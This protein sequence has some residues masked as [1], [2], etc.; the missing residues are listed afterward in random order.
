MED[1]KARP[2]P[3]P[4]PA[5]QAPAPAA[6]PRENQ[7]PRADPRKKA[8][9][10]TSI[11]REPETASVEGKKP[12]GIQGKRAA[13][14]RN[15]V[16]QGSKPIAEDVRTESSTIAP[17]KA[18][19]REA[20]SLPNLTATVPPPPVKDE[21]SWPTP[22]KAE[23]TD[24]EKRKE[25][26]DKEA[27]NSA[28]AG[29]T[30]AKPRERTKWTPMAVT[31]S[32]VWQ[33]EEMNRPRGGA[34][35]RARGGGRGGPN[36]GKGERNAPRKEGAQGE[37][38]NSKDAGAR[39][40]TNTVDREVMPPPTKAAKVSASESREGSHARGQD[41]ANR[42]AKTTE[43]Q[44]ETSARRSKSP[45]QAASASLNDKDVKLPEPIP[46]QTPNGVANNDA[47]GNVDGARDTP[48]RQSSDGKKESR[49]FENAGGKEWNGAPRGSK[50][51]G[52]GRGGSRE[53]VNGH[54]PTQPFAN[55]SAEFTN[56][57]SVPHSPGF[58]SPRGGFG[59]PQGRGGWRGNSRSQSIPIENL[60]PGRF[61]YPQQLP[62]VQTYYPGMYELNMSM[63]AM[64]APPMVDQQSV[65]DMVSTQIE[66][67]FSID[68]LLKD[69]FLRKNMDSQGFVFMDVIIN[70][71]R[72]KTLTS[73]KELLKAVCLRSENIE[74][75]VGEDGKERL[76]RREGWEKFLLPV[77]QRELAAQTDGPQVLSMPERPEQHFFS[78]PPMPF[79]SPQSAG[80]PGQHPRRSY[81]A[82]YA[83]NGATPGFAPFSPLAEP[84]Y[85][86][87]ANG[88]EMRGRA[89]KSP[90]R[91]DH[92]AAPGQSLPQV[93]DADIDP[94][95]FPNEQMNTLTVVVKMNS[96]RPHHVAARTFSNGSIDTRNIFGEIEK[97]NEEAVKPTTNG[98][99]Q[100]N[101][102]GSNPSTSR[103]ASPNTDRSP[104]K[105]NGNDI[106]LLWVKDKELPQEDLPQ[107]STLEP[108]F[109]LRA[110]A[111][112]QRDQA[113][114]G[115]CPYDLDV[116]YQFWSHFLIRNFN[117]KMYSEFKY[118][119][120]DDAQTRHNGT[121]IQN[122]VQFYA[123]ALASS[124]Q[125]RDHIV[126]DYVQLVKSEPAILQGLA[127]KQLR[128][129]WRNGALNL[130][131]RKKLNDIVDEDLRT[132]LEA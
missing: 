101:G 103:G 55:G 124:N 117:N 35:T 56:P 58:Q 119:A 18:V 57:Y 83:M 51:G 78:P 10:V 68:N 116:L 39:G 33:T 34:S 74:I 37:G 118:F 92:D 115:T 31:P 86:D 105:A 111:L 52:R 100:T 73:D 114:T 120:N 66:Y 80:L 106:M 42:S 65:M 64:M 69:M 54:Q 47:R 82:S 53:F 15:H 87:M 88:D 113:S 85:A 25:A 81:D 4:Q 17:A 50:R 62:P 121:G 27:E 75:R 45:A 102:E 5:K 76:R 93:A 59:Y 63:S 91:A 110:K 84:P 70:F 30:E 11:A 95:V 96:H 44:S 130:K 104:D 12:N 98:E 48:K 3:V 90:N 89:T 43:G 94:D 41:R 29:G 131:N 14:V 60:Y 108:Y 1:A 8:T 79:R 77:D 23:K 16:R 61:A 24:E 127:F 2:V 67:Y 6:A 128:Q 72:I 126:K 32:I 26:S 21:T 112:E 125:I 71:N 36:A 19:Q 99:A 97:A 22:D 122:L 9:S 38:D 7:K 46:R 28:D 123:K 132:K 49:N 20:Q 129:A 107:D 13:E 40:R 109:Q